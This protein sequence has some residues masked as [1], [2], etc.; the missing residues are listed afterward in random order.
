MPDTTS[1][2]KF[3]NT[4]RTGKTDIT[5]VLDELFAN[6]NYVRTNSG[7]APAFNALDSNANSLDPLHPDIEALIRDRLTDLPQDSP[8]AIDGLIDHINNWY[9]PGDADKTT[10]RDWLLEAIYDPLNIPV[11]FFWRLDASLKNEKH[12]RIKNDP[13]NHNNTSITF[14]TPEDRVTYEAVTIE[15]EAQVRVGRK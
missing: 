1:I 9:D 4:L 5:R 7:C 14:Y 11:H 2:K 12:I 10:L 8:T 6:P 15:G 3:I 13:L